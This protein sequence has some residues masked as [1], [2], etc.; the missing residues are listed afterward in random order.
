MS[1]P[2]A[3]HALLP[4]HT[5]TPDPPSPEAAAHYV[6]RTAAYDPVRVCS[7]QSPPST[8]RQQTSMHPPADRQ[9]A[10]A[11]PPADHQQNPAQPPATQSAAMPPPRSI[12]PPPSPAYAFHPNML[13]SEAH[14]RHHRIPAQQPAQP[15]PRPMHPPAAQSLRRQQTY[16]YTQHQAQY[17]YHPGTHAYRHNAPHSAANQPPTSYHQPQA[18]QQLSLAQRQAD[19]PSMVAAHPKPEPSQH[20]PPTHVSPSHLHH[21]RPY[22]LQPTAPASRTFWNHYETGLL[23]QLWLEFEAQFLANKRNAGVWA[24]LAQL[25]TERSGRHRTVRECRIKWKNMWAKHR[26]L[27]NASHMSL[28]A[29]LREFPHF[30]QF[31]AIRQRGSQQHPTH[32]NEGP[33]GK[34]MPSEDDCRASASAPSDTPQSK[35][36][37]R[38]PPTAVAGPAAHSPRHAYHYKPDQ[39]AFGVELPPM[40]HA[41]ATAPAPKDHDERRSSLASIL[42]TDRHSDHENHRYKSPS[43]T[44]A[45]APSDT[46]SLSQA[47]RTP[48]SLTEAVSSMAV[49]TEP[50]LADSRG[51]SASQDHAVRATSITDIPLLLRQVDSSTSCYS[52]LDGDEYSQDSHIPSSMR[53]RDYDDGHSKPLR[54]VT[55]SLSMDN[56]I[57]RMWVLAGI[58]TSADVSA[59]AQRIMSYVERESKR[60]QIQSERHYRVVTELAEI[61]TRSSVDTTAAPSASTSRRSSGPAHELL[62]HSAARPCADLHMIHEAT[63]PVGHDVGSDSACR[64]NEHPDDNGDSSNGAAAYDSNAPLHRAETHTPPAKPGLEPPSQPTATSPMDT[65]RADSPL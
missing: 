62:S 2:E 8:P 13:T 59:A 9:P 32:P 38:E 12:P 7:S 42:I 24:Q 49:N 5:A 1:V 58:S 33:E 10:P 51:S 26:D 16:H 65:T 57:E 45:A 47:R 3:A 60:R 54:S 20:P 25:L 39:V 22:E 50:A 17:Q 48:S 27:A 44:Y 28:D 36:A 30:S 37:Y 43:V 31:T 56:V 41:F 11:H 63:S 21:H 4:H 15:Q 53:H 35:W 14:D 46:R 18:A 40:Q 61:L 6:C 29:K 34:L 55:G 19:R 23:V 52:A 64:F